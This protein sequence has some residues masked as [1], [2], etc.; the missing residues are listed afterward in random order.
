M[1]YQLTP[2]KQLDILRSWRRDLLSGRFRQGRNRLRI[3]YHT[4]GTTQEYCC[5]GVLCETLKGYGDDVLQAVGTSQYDLER[6]LANQT[7]LPVSFWQRLW[8]VGKSTFR[9]ISITGMNLMAGDN[10]RRVSFQGIVERHIDPAI[11]RLEA[12]IAAEQG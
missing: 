1:T 4:N 10:D 7:M 12:E 2:A 3:Q 6:L 5:L 11:E 9:L 8:R